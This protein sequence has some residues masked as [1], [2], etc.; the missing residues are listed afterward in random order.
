M[1]GVVTMRKK[2]YQHLRPAHT[3][4]VSVSK[5]KIYPLWR[6]LIIQLLCIINKPFIQ[7]LGRLLQ[8]KQ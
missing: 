2:G 3:A 4:F 1:L 8:L 5:N 7:C 6:Q